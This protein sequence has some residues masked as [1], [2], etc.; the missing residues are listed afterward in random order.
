[1]KVKLNKYLFLLFFCFTEF[2]FSQRLIDRNIIINPLIKGNK[3]IDLNVWGEFGFY[4][5]KT[6][7]DHSWL[8][9]LG[10][11]V[12]FYKTENFSFSGISSI[13]FIA[14]PHN[15]IR[16]NPRAIF[17]DEGFFITQKLNSSFLQV[18]YYHRC[19][20]DV[21]NLSWKKERTLIYGSISLKYLIPNL[22][23]KEFENYLQSRFEL[24]TLKY[25]HKTPK[26]AIKY[27]Y[28]KL[29]AT[30]GLNIN[31]NKK[32]NDMFS[33]I[34]KPNFYLNLYSDEKNLVE[35]FAKIYQIVPYFG[36]NIGLGIGN[37]NLILLLF[38]YEYLFDAGIEFEPSKSNLISFSLFLKSL[39]IK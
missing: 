10:I 5:I 11:V 38:N 24:Y 3:K 19:K 26:N 12:D 20:H 36:I 9:K 21:D 30:L 23:F 16:F 22:L 31:F 33:L 32:L 25:D 2:I 37:E 34:V 18:G 17:W 6:D 28:D 35:Q 7:D 4:R 1:M 29:A 8:Q 39:V 14:D 15:D 13:E 27:G